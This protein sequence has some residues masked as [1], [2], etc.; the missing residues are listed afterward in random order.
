MTFRSYIS[1]IMSRP[2]V[3]LLLSLFALQMRATMKTDTLQT[4]IYYLQGDSAFNPDLRH[5]A[6]NL[7]R[8]TDILSRGRVRSINITSS[9]SPEG[10]TAQ[11]RKLSELRSQTVISLINLSS[12]KPNISSIG[13]DWNG[14][15]NLLSDKEVPFSKDLI[16]IVNNTPEWITERGV[17]VD[18]RKRRLRDLNSGK[19][20]NYMLDNVFPELRV[21]RIEIVYYPLNDLSVDHAP[22]EITERPD[23]KNIKVG[24][25]LIGFKT[26]DGEKRQTQRI[27]H[28][29]VRTN[30]LYD[31]VAVPNLGLTAYVGKTWSVSIDGLYAD[32]S[33][34]RHSRFWRIQGAELSV[35][36]D[37][38]LPPPHCTNH[39]FLEVYL[40]LCR[41]NI[42]NGT[43]GYLSGH[44][45]ADFFSSPTFG[46]GIGGGYSI[47]LS[48]RL[49]LD[50]SIGVGYLT[51]HYQTYKVDDYHLVWQSTRLRRYFGLTKA[52]I[53]LVWFFGK[54]GRL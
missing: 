48:D 33:D 39:W 1:F 47:R 21:S 29:A 7:E 44:S 31:A 26:S 3:L 43:K 32:W 30:L 50:L 37:I 23:L 8:I 36:K 41:Y 22:S 53:S 45:E 24:D 42:C 12:I 34:S 49:S 2:A 14:L 46:A 28:F 52:G 19:P 51:G 17:V 54:G 5:N 40:Q 38:C 4:K 18:G 13:T 6:E 16:D 20:W 9:A 35:R 11:N 10:N 25:A 15:V 27:S